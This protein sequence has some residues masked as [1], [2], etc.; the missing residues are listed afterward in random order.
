MSARSGLAIG[1][2]ALVVALAGCSSRVAD[3]P[4]ASSA[5]ASEWLAVARGQVDVEGGMV[6]VVALAGGV[7]AAVKVEQGEHVAAGQVLATLDA[8]AAENAVAVAKSSVVEAEATLAELQASLKQATWSAEHLSA[9]A[10]EGTA[11]GAAAVEARST[12]ATLQAKQAAAKAVL[13][14]TRHQL[15]GAQLALDETTLRAPVAGTV[16]TRDVALGQAVAAASGPPLFTLLPDRPYIVRAQVDARDAAHLQPGMRAEVQRDSGFGPVYQA[17]V[18]R[19]GKVLQS[20]TMAPS[21]LERA[22]ADDVDCTLRL[23]PPARGVEPLNVG[24]RVVV[25]FPRQQ[26]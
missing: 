22:L 10:R 7:V 3:Q 9:A 18:L 12:L 15:A 19:V 21:P 17:T 8:R 23:A 1:I 24:Q 4:P 5:P 2:V 11:T 16:V 26:H 20:A 25:K 13:D 14:A 6:Q